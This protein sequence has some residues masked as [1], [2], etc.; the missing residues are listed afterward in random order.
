MKKSLF[1]K[2]L[3]GYLLIIILL[4]VLILF[5]SFRTIREYYIESLTGDLTHLCYTLETQ[6]NLTGRGKALPGD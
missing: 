2:S 4:S 5:F 3:G 6:D 1:A